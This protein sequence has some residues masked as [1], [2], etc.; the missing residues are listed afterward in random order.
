[1]TFELTAS[2]YDPSPGCSSSRR[3]FAHPLGVGLGARRLAVLS[4][5]LLPVLFVG[6]ALLGGPASV[7]RP[8]SERLSSLAV[9]LGPERR[10]EARLV[11][12]DR[13]QACTPTA[14]PADALTEKRCGASLAAVDRRAGLALE[15]QARNEPSAQQARDGALWRL[16]QPG[17]TPRALEAAVRELEQAVALAPAPNLWSDL[18]ALYHLRAQRRAH[19]EDLI[20]ALGAAER[21]L[22]LAPE[23]IEARFNRALVLEALGLPAAV[24]AWR[25]VAAREVSHAWAA[26]ARARAERLEA[27]HAQAVQRRDSTLGRQPYQSE[28]ERASSANAAGSAP[29]LAAF[30]AGRQLYEASQYQ[31][32][33]RRFRA[34][35]QA[36]APIDG[37][38]AA[39][40]RYYVAVC[41][42]R[43][44][45]RSEQ[46][47]A[48]FEQ[49]ARRPGLPPRLAAYV[50]WMRGLRAHEE[51]DL[52]AALGLYSRAIEGL[53]ADGLEP[54]AAFVRSLRAAVVS[55]LSG[56]RQSWDDLYF[57]LRDPARWGKPRWQRSLFDTLADESKRLGEPSVARHFLDLA[58]AATGSLPTPAV[59]ALARRALLRQELG[60]L[61][62]AREDVAAGS[63]LVRGAT[64]VAEVARW[65]LLV[66]ESRV[67]DERERQSALE[68]LSAAL[69]WLATQETSVDVPGL[70]VERA[71][72]WQ[73]EGER[74]AAEADLGQALRLAE[75]AAARIDRETWR[76]AYA[77]ASREAV[78]LALGL[79][80]ERG[81]VEGAFV[82]AERARRLEFRL[83]GGP[84]PTLASL[85][86]DLAA[87]T[88]VVAYWQLPEA[89]LVWV[90]TPAGSHFE[91]LPL[92]RAELAT[93]IRSF[94]QALQVPARSASARALAEVLAADL[95]AP[96]LPHLEGVE[97]L[98]VV[99]DAELFE[100]PFAALVEPGSGRPLLERFTL[101]KSPQ[102]GPASGLEVALTG[103][104]AR[105]IL[106]VGDPRFDSTRFPDLAVQL[107][108]AEQ[109]ARAIAQGYPRATQLLGEAATSDRVAALLPRV[110]VAH[111][112][113]HALSDDELP[114]LTALALT[115]G[116]ARA[117]AGALTAGEIEE[118][119][120]ERTELVVLA[121]CASA[122]SGPR[123]RGA[124]L[125]L[126]RAFLA[127]GTESVIGTLWPIEDA[128]TAPLT[129][130]LHE[131][132]R[133]G[134]P[135][136]AALRQAQRK[137]LQSPDPPPAA[138][139]AAFEIYT[140]PVET[141]H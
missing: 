15:R 91:R 92:V 121:A 64:A 113:A 130:A 13:W 90:V 24:E 74:G 76:S 65:K 1:M 50:A 5:S 48:G 112:A 37:A 59:E 57:A 43:L 7:P 106:V 60:D 28:I 63:R 4:R 118:L 67:A 102:A 53:D 82:L 33:G 21:A 12:L 105:G 71:R 34:A 41:D 132:L 115:R 100:L 3:V 27:F 122:R 107:P 31:D 89:L 110:R 16:L 119:P 18:A 49:L 19:P 117:G 103:L 52:V 97:R 51:D 98:L 141:H 80:L 116:P 84:L 96:V 114:E 36:L 72:L 81:E 135:P 88:G 35:A 23:A 70:L 56:S 22:G 124:V 42:S 25:E 45:G 73:A 55:R 123:D 133:T 131:A 111:F 125:G 40:A 47:R 120:L 127:A 54:E 77:G 139:W 136:A 95:V 66:A 78:D 83:G 138:L 58:V 11:G 137:L 99:P 93:R 2:A 126:A 29:G 61:E 17:A 38:L 10:I 62:G 14:A 134:L 46:A 87:G 6:L 140:H 104:E 75:R 68:Q 108:G 26:E 69:A 86:Q 85:R 79:A 44:A 9:A 129:T 32:A 39:W 94:R 128:S 109:E 101:A 20:R 30:E 8:T